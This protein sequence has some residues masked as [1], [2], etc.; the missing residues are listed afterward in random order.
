MLFGLNKAIV[1]QQVHYWLRSD[2]AQIRDGHRWVYNTYEKWRKDNF[3]FWS[4]RTIQRIFTDLEETGLV[5]AKA[6]NAHKW[7]QEKWYR[8]DYA[9][10]NETAKQSSQEVEV[11]RDNLSLR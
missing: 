10:L 7:D 5:I 3:P 8:I 1:L 4:V 9:K 2:K 11:E 6:F